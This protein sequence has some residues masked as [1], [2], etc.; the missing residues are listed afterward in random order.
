MADAI[1]ADLG[2]DASASIVQVAEHAAQQLGL[3]PSLGLKEKLEFAYVELGLGTLPRVEAG[4][5]G[6]H[7]GKHAG[8]A[9]E[10]AVRKLRI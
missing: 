6:A 4:T 2:L 10:A 9:P 8:A 3:G 5:A 7:A 1:R